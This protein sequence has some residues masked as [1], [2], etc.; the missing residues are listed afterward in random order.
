M[1]EEKININDMIIYEDDDYVVLNKPSGVLSIPDRFNK[2]LPNFYTLLKTKYGQIYII[3]RLDKDTSG[4][5]CFGKNAEA[6]RDLNI[7]FDKGEVYKTYI[8]LVC[9]KLKNKTGT[10]NLPIAPSKNKKGTMVIDKKYGK[11]AITNYAVLGE[12]R[13]YSLLE[14]HP[15]TGRTHQ[16]RIHLAA[17][18]YPLA[19]DPIYNK[20][21][22]PILLS[23][24]K[25]DYK[26]HNEKEEKPIISRLTLHAQKIE[27]FHFRKKE[28]VCF[29]AKFHNDF[30]LLIKYLEKYGT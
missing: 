16:I 6:H 17:I 1:S 4:V 12:Y 9:G 23:M 10:I 2:D 14:I 13:N 20:D 22:K 19:I 27:F 3:H 24:L 26:R 30:K 8:A 7:K 29:E 15:E 18:G 28:N 25:K 11:V 5:I 21:G